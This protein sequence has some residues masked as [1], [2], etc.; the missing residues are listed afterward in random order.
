M[1]WMTIKPIK[2]RSVMWGHLTC[3][4][5]GNGMTATLKGAFQLLLGGLYR[6]GNGS[7]LCLKKYL[8]QRS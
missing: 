4:N 7:K 3:R 5:E 1:D 6:V 8:H 2:N